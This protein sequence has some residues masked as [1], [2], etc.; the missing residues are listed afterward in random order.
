MGHASS[1]PTARNVNP[2]RRDPGRRDGGRRAGAEADPGGR[3]PASAV[4]RLTADC[5]TCYQ[6]SLWPR[7]DRSSGGGCFPG[8]ETVMGVRQTRPVARQSDVVV[9]T[10]AGEV[11]V[12]DLRHHRAHSLNGVAAAVWRRCDG[13]RDARAIAAAIG[14]AESRRVTEET[15][16]YAV[17]QLAQAR[18]LTGSAPESGV[19]RRE[20][21]RR[22][23]ATAAVAV[24]VVTSIASPTAAQAQ[25]CVPGV[26]IDAPCTPN[27]PP[28]CIPIVACI[29]DASSSTGFSCN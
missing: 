17:A 13:S 4:D 14:R 1:S 5:W 28:C 21:L 10:V 25:S 23:G 7:P 6:A 26:G 2:G 3:C 15:V 12:Y 22:L 27:G 8:K 24:P 9:K 18:L 29:T 11:L 16:R 19:T 20:W